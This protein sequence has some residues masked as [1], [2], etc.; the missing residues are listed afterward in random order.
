MVLTSAEDG[1]RGCLLLSASRQ[2]HSASCRQPKFKSGIYI[3][4]PPGLP[5][6]SRKNPKPTETPGGVMVNRKYSDLSHLGA[7]RSVVATVSKKLL[8]REGFP[9][10]GFLFFV[11]VF[12]IWYDGSGS[13]AGG[14]SVV[15]KGR[16]RKGFSVNG[17]TLRGCHVL[18]TGSRRGSFEVLAQ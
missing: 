3:I 11:F 2:S 18:P 15:R 4:L 17:A 1:I 16:A 14:I 10:I 6:I 8:A 9:V 7:R 5:R 12:I 13:S